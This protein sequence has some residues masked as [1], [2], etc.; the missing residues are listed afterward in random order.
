MTSNMELI[1]ELRGITLAG[2]SECK[3]ALEETNG[4]INKSID[5]IKARGLQQVSNLESKIA[6]EGRISILMTRSSN[7]VNKSA[8]MMECN[9]QTDFSS[10]SDDFVDFTDECV[11]AVSD[12]FNGTYKT[13]EEAMS[14]R[15]SPKIDAR[16]NSTRTLTQV[17]QDLMV[18]TKEKIEVRRWWALEAMADNTCVHSYMHSN[19][20]L[21]VLVSFEV[22]EQKDLTNPFFVEFANNVA[23]QIAAMAPIALSKEDINPEVIERQKKIFEMQ[24]KEL[25]KPEATWPKIL[26]GKM[27]KF[28]AES[29]L[30]T[31]E[32]VLSPKKTVQQVMDELSILLCGKDKGVKILAYSRALVGD[33]L[34]LIK[35]DLAETV[36]KT[37]K[38]SENK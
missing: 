7:D 18:S 9:T 30:L 13:V 22:P 19:N 32:S 36:E 24:V 29:A 3:K 4:D 31:Q 27:N 33:G 28:I 15:N 8:S 38:D 21:G 16:H 14:N 23:M 25:N 11:V 17:K 35:E 10:Q 37:I 2:I 6:T 26:D 20:K 5:I 34:V 12:Y 1:K